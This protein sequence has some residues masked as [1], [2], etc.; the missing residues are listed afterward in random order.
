MIQ[1]KL[2]EASALL[3]AEDYSSAIRKATSALALIAG[4]PD[5]EFDDQRIEWRNAKELLELLLSQAKE[6]KAESAASGAGG[7]L[8]SIPVRRTC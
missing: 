6:L 8:T 2:R 3:E 7:G 5:Q 4:K 1:Q